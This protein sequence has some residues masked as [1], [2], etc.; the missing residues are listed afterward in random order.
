MVKKRGLGKNL[1]AL[2][3]TKIADMVSDA[4]YSA[5]MP[6]KELTRIAIDKLKPSRFQPRKR[7]DQSALNELAESI[8]R[9]GL[10][11]PIVVRPI[12]DD[13]YEIIAGERRWRA[14]KLADLLEVPVVIRELS[15]QAASAIAL[16]ENIQREDLNPIEESVA[17]QRMLEEHNLTHQQLAD[18][19][20][21][22]RT[23]VTNLLRLNDC[24]AE[25]KQLL[26]DGQLEMGHARALLALTGLDQ[27][28]QAN[29]VIDRKLSVRQ[30]EQLVQQY[31]NS[32][33]DA[34]RSAISDQFIDKPE[35]TAYE[36]RLTNAFGHK[37][38]IKPL[39][40]GK[41]NIVVQCD[42]LQ[43]LVELIDLIG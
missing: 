21:K 15:D 6:E 4:S 29:V 8:R 39:A 42:S 36:K 43:G 13:R 14:S 18:M 26:I 22:S 1:D 37:S 19:I 5:V 3:G 24:E 10:I 27:V 9:Q 25:I 41:F 38:R 23:A 16:I 33:V 11:Q 31:L 34:E 40:S 17:L 35:R 12:A 2:L 20:G 30:T 32:V 28:T 7:I